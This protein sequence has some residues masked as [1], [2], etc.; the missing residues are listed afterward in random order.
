M[1]INV[2]Q[3]IITNQRLHKYALKYKQTKNQQQNIFVCQ[4]INSG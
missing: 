2:K 3:I 4:T 1:A